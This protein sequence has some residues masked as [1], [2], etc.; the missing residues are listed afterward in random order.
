MNEWIQTSTCS[1]HEHL[2]KIFDVLSSVLGIRSVHVNKIKL[3][4]LMGI[5]IS[6]LKKQTQLP[7]ESVRF[8]ASEVFKQTTKTTD[9]GC[10]RDSCLGEMLD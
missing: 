8:L 3:S 6:I 4:S 10:R 7:W 2:L 5:K 9:Q 1:G